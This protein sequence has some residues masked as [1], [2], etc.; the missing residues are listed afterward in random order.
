M[1]FNIMELIGVDLVVV[2]IVYSFYDV[3]I[4]SWVYRMF[5]EIVWVA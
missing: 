3:F 1:A 5:M 2:L 4:S